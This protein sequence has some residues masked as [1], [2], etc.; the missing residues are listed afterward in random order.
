MV[1]PGEVSAN[2]SPMKVWERLFTAALRV[3]TRDFR[4]ETLFPER[5][6]VIYNIE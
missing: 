2:N 3:N 5:D 4:V 1:K 6:G